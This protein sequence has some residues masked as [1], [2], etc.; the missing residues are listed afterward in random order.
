MSDVT[1]VRGV[2]FDLWDTLVD[3]PHEQMQRLNVAIADHIGIDL[4]ELHQRMRST[5]RISQ[6]GPFER[7]LRALGVPD[8]H[9]PTHV[10][11]RFAFTRGA[12]NPREGV[13]QT[14]AT[15]RERGIRTGL[16]SMCSEDVAVTWPD[17]TLAPLID[18]AT[19]SAT[20]GLVKPEPEIYLHTAET[21]GVPP[22]ECLFVGDGA[23][24]E[25]VGAEATGM[26]SVLIV[27][28]G[29]DPVWHE[30]RDWR[31]QRVATIPEV[32]ELC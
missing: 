22:S 23:N 11:A 20:T 7:A 29:S 8:E 21:L 18:V 24:N 25:L 26:T 30:V 17:T 15:L 19:F 6:T 10:A 16:I 14:L 9:V 12:L 3:W 5:Y 28:A 1:S 31:G 2:I 13:L 32:L 27:P 4:P